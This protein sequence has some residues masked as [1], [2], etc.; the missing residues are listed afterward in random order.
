MEMSQTTE[1]KRRPLVE[2][3]NAVDRTPQ[4]NI[5]PFE[6]KVKDTHSEELITLTTYEYPAVGETRAV[7]FFFPFYGSHVN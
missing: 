4:F 5:N 3:I 1:N 6:L 7:L 2:R